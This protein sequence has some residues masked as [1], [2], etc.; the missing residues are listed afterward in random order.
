MNPRLTELYEQRGFLRARIGMEREA[1]AAHHDA[2]KVICGAGDKVLFGARW[3]RRHPLLTGTALTLFAALRPGRLARWSWWGRRALAL[4]RFL[5]R[6][7]P[8]MARLA[9]FRNALF[10]RRKNT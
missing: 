5:R 2:L 10:S 3:I 1:L 9:R 4:W 7:R 6:V 8:G